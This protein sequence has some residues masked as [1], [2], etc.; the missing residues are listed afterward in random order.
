MYN[1]LTGQII[2]DFRVLEGKLNTLSYQNEE[3][4]IIEEIFS[5]VL[6]SVSKVW[7]TVE[8]MEKHINEETEVG[9]RMLAV[10]YYGLTCLG[11]HL[12]S[13]VEKEATSP[14]PKHTQSH[15]LT[16]TKLRDD[17]HGLIFEHNLQSQDFKSIT[18]KFLKREEVFQPL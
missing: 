13:V 6:Q 16:L 18:K 11:S 12:A 5:V 17:A 7:E 14:L 3:H 4:L 2:D 15:R 8:Y 10:K 1:S 9:F